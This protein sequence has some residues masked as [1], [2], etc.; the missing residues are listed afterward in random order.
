ML[1]P[2][3]STSSARSRRARR[4][5]TRS[6]SRWATDRCPSKPTNIATCVALP[7][8]RPRAGLRRGR[9]RGRARASARA[10]VHQGYIEP[11][12][13]VARTGEDGKILIWCSTQG[14]FMVQTMSATAVLRP[15]PEPDQGDPER[16]RRRLRR[17]DHD[18][19]RAGRGRA[20]ARAAHRPVKLVMTREEV[21]RATGP[22]S[23]TQHPDQARREARRHPRRGARRDLDYEAGAYRGLAGRTR[24]DDGLRPATRSRTSRSKA[25][26]SLVNKPKVAAYR[27]PGAPMA[28][29][30]MES[31]IDELA[32]ELRPRSDRAPAAERGRARATRRPTA[33]STGRSDSSRRLRAAKKHPHYKAPL[34][35]NQG[36]GIAAASGST[37]ACSR[38]RSSR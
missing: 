19:P 2:A 16:D 24:R 32:R 18:L 31:V 20:L 4:S 28:N 1:E 35:K 8:R 13:C 22:T 30:A 6:S 9:R 33:R 17:Q 38:A 27:A 37:R 3:C 15:R 34:G 11:H 12:A 14:A 21:F 26:T 29:F 5:C 36:R 10:M 7:A 25:S 23:G